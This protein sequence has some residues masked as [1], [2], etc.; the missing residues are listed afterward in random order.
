[1]R[2]H[3]EAVGKA[4]G[5][6][7]GGLGNSGNGLLLQP[8]ATCPP[9]PWRRRMRPEYQQL[10]YTRLRCGR[11][12]QPPLDEGQLQQ[13]E[14]EDSQPGEPFAHPETALPGL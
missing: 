13:A 8:A 6:E 11:L 3:P 1:M 12:R 14:E 10:W 9:Q 7:A 4:D 2:V 5:S